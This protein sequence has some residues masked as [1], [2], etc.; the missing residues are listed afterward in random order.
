MGWLVLAFFVVAFAGLLGWRIM[1]GRRKPGYFAIVEY[2]I[3]SDAERLPPTP[4]LMDG[5]V[6]RSPH[7]KPNQP[8]I[9]AREGI[10]F[11]DLRLHIA[12][13]KREKNPHAFRPDLF[14]E[15]AVPDAD[16][17]QRLADSK[18]ITKIQYASEVPLKDGRHLQ[19][20]THLVES[21]ARTSK[22]RLIFDTVAERF[23][24]PEELFDAL[25]KDNNAE[26]ADLHLR[27][28][29]QK[30]VDGCRAQTLGLKKIGRQELQTSLQEVDQEVIVV[31]LV[32]LAA[33]SLFID[34]QRALPIEVKQHGDTFI[35]SEE[36]AKDGFTQ[37]KLTRRMFV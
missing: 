24:I 30:T 16:I 23:W 17:L 15:H 31:G 33:Q 26:R 8:S 5:I 14:E 11:S 9:T 10:L 36:S 32:E 4:A 34:P 22:A 27:V 2:W 18:A 28:V 21:L 1:S 12:L 19:F 35:V 20:V 3:Y 13:A 29:W 37:I 6:S 25:Q 7:S